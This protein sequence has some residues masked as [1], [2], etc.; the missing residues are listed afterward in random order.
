VQKERVQRSSSDPQ[1]FGLFWGRR[2]AQ[3]A[4]RGLGGCSPRLSIG[5]VHSEGVQQVQALS[6]HT[7]AKG[8][9][10]AQA[11][12]GRQSPV[13]QTPVSGTVPRAGALL[14]APWGGGQRRRGKGCAGGPGHA[15][16]KGQAGFE[17][18]WCRLLGWARAGS[19]RASRTSPE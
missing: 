7:R 19:S 12:R 1:G 13:L 5:G 11:S 14:V 15:V 3:L 4:P 2:S 9:A 8:R 10:D 16:G 18:S 6:D 17:H